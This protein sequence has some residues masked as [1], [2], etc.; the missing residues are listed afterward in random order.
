[1]YKYEDLK[2]SLFT[3]DGQRTF[4][5]V[6]DRVNN[7][8]KQAGAVRLEE[9]IKGVGGDSWILLACIDRLVELKEL[10]EVTEKAGCAQ[11]RVFVG[12]RN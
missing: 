8:L 9:A 4:L 2:P 10:Y 6:R 12:R 1:M 3:D 7:L 5:Q 11:D